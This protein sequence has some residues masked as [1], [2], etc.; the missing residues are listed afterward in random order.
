MSARMSDARAASRVMELLKEQTRELAACPCKVQRLKE[1]NRELR[2]IVGPI[3]RS[4][5]DDAPEE[6][7]MEQVMEEV[8]DARWAE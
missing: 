4:L 8:R 2:D 1:I 6:R 5:A 3:A 7:D